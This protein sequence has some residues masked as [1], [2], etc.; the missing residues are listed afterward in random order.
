MTSWWENSLCKARLDAKIAEADYL[1]E[2]DNKCVALIKEGKFDE[3]RKL[4]E[5]EFAS[6]PKTLCVN[7]EHHI[8]LG[9]D[10][11]PSR[12]YYHYCGAHPRK[13]KTDPVSGVVGYEKYGDITVQK[14]PHCRDINNGNCKY[15]KAKVS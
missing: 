11:D 3:A 4:V 15:F 12:W 14:Y 9:C 5:E 7:C 1:I 6:Q 10:S 8:F 2:L 13:L